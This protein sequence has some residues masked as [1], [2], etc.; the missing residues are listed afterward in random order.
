MREAAAIFN[1]EK[2]GL[3]AALRDK[4]ALLAQS[5]AEAES[6]RGTMRR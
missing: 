5:E 4:E 3:A 6:L 2:E 1:R